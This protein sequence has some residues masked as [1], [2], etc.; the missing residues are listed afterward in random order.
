MYATGILKKFRTSETCSV[1]TNWFPSNLV[2]RKKINFAF[3][4][5]QI[6][7][8]LQILFILFQWT[9]K[10][11]VFQTP[12]DQNLKFLTLIANF[13]YNLLSKIQFK[14]LKLILGVSTPDNVTKR[15]LKLESIQSANLVDLV[16]YYINTRN[17]VVKHWVHT[18]TLNISMILRMIIE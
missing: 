14:V 18:Y 2:W 10:G 11:G 17:T 16:F 5:S 9:R 8:L 1:D 4:T 3:F 15:F 13:I 7:K 12:N 6:W